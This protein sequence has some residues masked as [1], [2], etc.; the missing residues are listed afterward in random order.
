[1]K[2]RWLGHASFLFTTEKGITVLTD[3]YVPGAYD[4][5]VRYGK[6]EAV[7]DIVTVSH[8][9]ADHNGVRD[10][11]GSPQVV[12]GSGEWELKGIK[13]Q[14]ISTFHDQKEG[15]DRG[16]NT[17]F[18]Y[19]MDNLRL[20]HLGD[21]GHI[22]DENVVKALGRVDIIFVPVGGLYTID[23]RQAVEVVKLLNPRLVIPMHFKTPKLGFNIARVDEFLKL[24]PRGKELGK[25]E[26]EVKAESL[27]AETETWVLLPAL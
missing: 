9:H 2:V 14:G 12:R 22:P 23:A 5:A 19:E 16:T 8:E 7:A 11:P 21:L 1:M 26:V 6:I 15:R 13:I 10:L 17:M 24:A 3:P 18:C 25:S 27:P 20:V 4:G